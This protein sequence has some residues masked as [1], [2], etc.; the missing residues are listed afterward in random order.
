M[1][2]SNRCVLSSKSEKEL[3]KLGECPLDPGGY[4]IVKGIEKVILIHEQL[5]KNRIIIDF[6]AHDEVKA[7]V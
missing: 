6:D 1:L 2:R 5:A 4:F 3:D 7:V